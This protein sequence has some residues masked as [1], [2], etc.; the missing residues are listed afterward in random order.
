MTYWWFVKIAQKLERR[1]RSQVPM[2]KFPTIGACSSHESGGSQKCGKSIASATTFQSPSDNASKGSDD[3]LVKQMRT[4]YWLSQVIYQALFLITT[5]TKFLRGRSLRFLDPPKILGTPIWPD[6]WVPGPR[7][8]NPSA[9]PDV[10]LKTLKAFLLFAQF[11]IIV[12][13]LH[14]L[15]F[16]GLQNNPWKIMG[17]CKFSGSLEISASQFRFSE[18]RARKKIKRVSEA[19]ILDSESWSLS[20]ASQV[21]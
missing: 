18:F 7:L 8:K 13:W 2:Q 10:T 6:M 19:R 11:F 20:L 1:T 14:V 12:K 9:I 16:T 3:S 15:S 5:T 21:V 17:L 4:A